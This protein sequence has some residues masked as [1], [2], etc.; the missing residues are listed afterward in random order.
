MACLAW[1]SVAISLALAPVAAPWTH[2][3]SDSWS[4]SSCWHS[5]PCTHMWTQNREPLT[6]ERVRKEFNKMIGQTALIRCK[7]QP[8]QC[9]D[10]PT[11]YTWLALHLSL[12]LLRLPKSFPLHLWLLPYVSPVQYCT[13]FPLY[14]TW[15]TPTSSD[16]QSPKD[17]LKSFSP[18][19]ALMGVTLGQG[20]KLCWDSPGKVQR[21]CL[22]FWSP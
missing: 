11:L 3:H 16:H 15:P 10:Q 20:L 2:G 13:V 4:D 21:S 7:A 12:F 9:A 6:Q 5:D 18:S 1:S 22:F 14:P 8:G 17:G 19:L